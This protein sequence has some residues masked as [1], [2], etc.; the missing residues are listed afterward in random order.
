MSRA[1]TILA[2]LASLSAA[3]HLPA[4]AD[5]RTRVD[6]I[7]TRY[8]S[9]ATPGCA[10]GA[11]I[12]G[13]T[14]LTAAYG[15]ADL[16]HNAPITPETTFEPGSV[17]KQFTAASVF[18]LAQQGKLSIDDPVRKYIPELPDYGTPVTIRH[19]I[20]HTSGLRDW[21]SVAAI[22][23]WPRTTRAY[24][25]A[26]VLEIVSRQHALNYPP[27]ADYSYTNTGYNLL[28]ILVGRVSGKPLAEFSR[29]NIFVP[30]GM[31]STQWRDDFRR[32]VRNRA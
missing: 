8:H 11:S 17:T 10:V 14:V 5:A 2:L 6:Q 3:Q 19:L 13:E 15:M 4:P 1:L 22:G 16:E 32:I 25:H 23:G 9:T 21:G 30:L 27:G 31:S 18:L 29:D 26:H 20:N 28:A 7:F 24:T 12:D